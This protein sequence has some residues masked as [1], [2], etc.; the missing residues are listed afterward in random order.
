MNLEEIINQSGTQVIDVR[1]PQEFSGGHVA[2]SINI[3]LNE[4]PDHIE[5][6]KGSES[7]FVLCCASGMRSQQ[8]TG[9]LQSQGINNVVNGGSWLDVN[10]YKN[11]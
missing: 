9:Y 10:Y 11:K 3:P 7:A 2:E 6:F 1:T 4:I 5:K 8:A